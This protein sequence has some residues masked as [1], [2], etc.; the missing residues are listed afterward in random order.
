MVEEA[1]E[2]LGVNTRLDLAQLEAILR[3]RRCEE[4]MLAGVT[5]VNP[6][7]TIID[8]TVSIGQDTVV[9]SQT[10]ILGC[11]SVGAG[12]SIGPQVVIQ[13]STLGD[14]VRVEP[15]C[16]LRNCAIPPQTTVPAFSNLSSVQA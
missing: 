13:D 6:L 4:L 2:I 11:S 12:C 8:A 3:R 7:T 16:M 15:F 5:I 1:E 9:A 14:G 10:H